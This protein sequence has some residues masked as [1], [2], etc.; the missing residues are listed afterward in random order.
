MKSMAS[1]HKPELPPVRPK[2]YRRPLGL[3]PMDD[4]LHLMGQKKSTTPH[5]H[6]AQIIK[7]PQALTVSRRHNRYF[8]VHLILF[9]VTINLLLSFALGTL[10]SIQNTPAESDGLPQKT[11]RHLPQ[12][13]V[14]S[15]PE[16]IR[17]TATY[18]SLDSA[19]DST[20][21]MVKQMPVPPPTV[22]LE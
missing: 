3:E 14:Y 5:T 22:E 18:L 21:T 4:A 12:I 20:D 10:H 1:A 2:A 8:G 15:T 19:V 17:R 16:P 7:K 9:L 13:R 6:P 11:T